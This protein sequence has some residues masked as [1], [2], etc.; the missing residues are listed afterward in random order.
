MLDILLLHEGAVT[1]KLIVHL[2][3]YSTAFQHRLSVQPHFVSVFLNF[4]FP[5]FALSEET[6]AVRESSVIVQVMR[7]QFCEL[8][9]L[10]HRFGAKLRCL[11]WRD[12]VNRLLP[13]LFL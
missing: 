3:V 5:H 4:F 11:A 8:R 10:A 7:P 2:L 9:P 1:L 12:F 13:G 6:T